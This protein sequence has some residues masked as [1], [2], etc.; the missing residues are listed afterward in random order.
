[1][2]S[3]SIIM[4]TLVVVCNATLVNC[5]SIQYSNI[6]T[7]TNTI[8]NADNRFINKLLHQRKCTVSKITDLLISAVEFHADLI[9]WHWPTNRFWHLAQHA[10]CW[11]LKA[12][13]IVA[14]HSKQQRHQLLP[15]VTQY[16]LNIPVC[17]V[18]KQYQQQ[19]QQQPAII[20]QIPSIP[21][22]TSLKDS[23]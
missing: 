2:G 15:T 3:E 5:N 13:H 10:Y 16:M 19:W 4:I 14:L 7:K 12:T 21:P 11:L 17:F 20:H 18:F 6:A 22:L 9:S 1:M 8:N 23:R